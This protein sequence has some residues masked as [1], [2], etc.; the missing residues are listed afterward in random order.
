MNTAEFGR[1]EGLPLDASSSGGLVGP[2]L[3]PPEPNE[4]ISLPVGPIGFFFQT[5]TLLYI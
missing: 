4:W 1:Q 5:T 3:P 2:K